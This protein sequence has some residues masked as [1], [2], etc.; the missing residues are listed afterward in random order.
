MN[1]ICPLNILKKKLKK[2]HTVKLKLEN[3][4]KRFSIHAKNNVLTKIW[5]EIKYFRNKP[6]KAITALYNDNANT[7]TITTN[8]MIVKRQVQVLYGNFNL[9]EAIPSDNQL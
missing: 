4:T 2:F 8:E 1:K 5:K 6:S 7:K 3:T 9:V